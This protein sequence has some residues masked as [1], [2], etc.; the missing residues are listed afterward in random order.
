M[1]LLGFGGEERWLPPVKG[2]HAM[3]TV[4][5][6]LY[7]YQSS[8]V[9]TDYSE[10]VERLLARQHRRAMVVVLTNLRG[11]DGV[12]LIEPLRLMRKKHLVVL[13]SLREQSIDQ[14][15]DQEV[16]GVDDALSY[17]AVKDYVSE[18]EAVLKEIASHGILTLDETAQNFPV[19]LA[20]QYLKARDAV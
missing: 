16:V 1:G 6:H 7:D 13:A 12:E 19:A 18:R 17:L 2:G 8:P 15:L 11:E 4:L 5:N 14:T 10:G 9:P 20:N 3:T